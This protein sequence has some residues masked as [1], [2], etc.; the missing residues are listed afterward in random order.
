[1]EAVVISK[2]Y[3][4]NVLV[5]TTLALCCVLKLYILNFTKEK[6]TNLHFSK[7]AIDGVSPISVLWRNLLSLNKYFTVSSYKKYKSSPDHIR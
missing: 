6:E 4:S 2:T 1:M 3:S 5:G 7:I